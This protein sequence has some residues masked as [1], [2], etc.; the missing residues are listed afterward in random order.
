MS[1]PFFHLGRRDFINGAIVAIGGAMLASAAQQLN[2]PGF[3]Y[4]A[5]Q[6]GEVVKVAVSAAMV[7]LSKNL[8]TAQNGK[9]GGVL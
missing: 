1:N 2:V 4:A 8:L 9:L 6:W 7:Y 5:F 3:D